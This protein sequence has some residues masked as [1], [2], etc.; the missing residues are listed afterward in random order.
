[1]TWTNLHRVFVSLHLKPMRPRIT[2][3]GQ[4]DKHSDLEHYRMLVKHG[5]LFAAGDRYDVSL[6]RGDPRALFSQVFP[7]MGHYENQTE[8]ALCIES[9]CTKTPE[10]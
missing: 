8:A 3:N 4:C 2:K 1:M 9:V 6:S 10:G 7:R 5:E